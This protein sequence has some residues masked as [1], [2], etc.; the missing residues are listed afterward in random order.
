MIK[1]LS[2]ME[3]FATVAVMLALLSLLLSLVDAFGADFGLFELWMDSWIFKI[4]LFCAGWF[5]APWVH[6]VLKIK[7][8]FGSKE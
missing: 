4:G 7:S 8:T 1:S 2:L 3:R 6:S 5:I